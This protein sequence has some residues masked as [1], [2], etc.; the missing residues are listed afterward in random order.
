VRED[1]EY[2]ENYLLTEYDIHV[3]FGRSEVDAYYYEVDV[4]GIN[5]KRP[6][7]LQL[8]CLLHEAGHAIVRRQQGFEREFAFVSQEGRTQLSRV[9][10]IKEEIEAWEEGKKLA[11]KL[12]INFNEFR[13]ERYWRHQ[14]YK[15]IRWAVDQER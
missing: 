5:T 3:E 15:Y 9:D 12:G 6:V 4:I 11:Y 14:V 13:W 10:T 2:L 1:L 7:E 8:F